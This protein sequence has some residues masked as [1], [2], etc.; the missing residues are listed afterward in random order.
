[1]SGQG[2]LSIADEYIGSEITKRLM[3]KYAVNIKSNKK[4][5]KAA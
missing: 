2:Q 5:N 1:M 4:V 3:S